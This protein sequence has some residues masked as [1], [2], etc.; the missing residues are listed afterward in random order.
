MTYGIGCRCLLLLNA[1]WP[2]TVEL[3][4]LC[5]RWRARISGLA[6]SGPHAGWCRCCPMNSCATGSTHG[7]STTL[8]LESQS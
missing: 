4:L 2:A 1:R 7:V 8:R 6:R 5:M 3:L